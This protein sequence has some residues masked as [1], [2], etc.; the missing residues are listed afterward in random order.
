MEAAATRAMH[1]D[2]AAAVATFVEVLD[3]W[4]RVGDW[5]EQWVC[6]RYV[7]RLLI[8]LGADDDALFLHC[9]VLTAG[10]PPPLRPAPM[11]AL[12]DRL[13]A[14]RFDAYIAS[15]ADGPTAVARA[16]SSLQRH[17]AGAKP[18]NLTPQFASMGR[19]A[20]DADRGRL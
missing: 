8:R 10:K 7:T 3:H 15:A 18:R 6:L 12:V 14:D 2:P 5:A 4:D 19:R 9:A 20:H 1:G 11:E 16:R 13:G 17:A